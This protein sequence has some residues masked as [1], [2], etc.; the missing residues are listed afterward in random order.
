MKISLLLPIFLCGLLVHGVC[1]QMRKSGYKPP[2][3]KYTNLVVP[4]H[5]VSS[6]ITK[7]PKVYKFAVNEERF[8]KPSEARKHMKKLPKEAKKEARKGEVLKVNWYTYKVISEIKAE[9]E[10]SQLVSS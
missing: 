1:P 2:H 5:F 10:Y 3:V 8:K 6:Q 7:D 9:V 4:N